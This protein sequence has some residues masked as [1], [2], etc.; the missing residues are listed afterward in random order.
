M[1]E[2]LDQMSGKYSFPFPPYEIQ[3]QLM[4]AIY[5]VLDNRK[6]GVFESPTGTGKSLSIICATIQW[7]RDFEANNLND[8]S[9]TLKSL[10][11]QIDRLDIESKLSSDWIEKQNQKLMINRQKEEVVNELNRLEIKSQRNKCLSDRKNN[12]IIRKKF[13]L[14]HKNLNKKLK[15]DANCDSD[16]MSSDNEFDENFV[17]YCSDEEVSDKNEI[18]LEDPMFVRPKIYYCSRTHSQ[19]SQF[20]N[21]IKKTSYSRQERPLRTVPLGSRSNYCINDS[22]LKLNNS[23]LI[24]EKCIELQNSGNSKTKCQMYKK[25]LMTELKDEILSDAL[26]IEDLIKLGKGV[27][28]CPYYSSRLA[29]PEAEIVIVPYNILL[30]RAQRE[31]FGI[32]L[33][34]NVVI[35]D[36]AHNLIETIHNIHSIELKA[37]Q[38]MDALTQV[39][40]YLFKYKTRLSARNTMHIKQIVFILNE[41]IKH[42]K[43]NIP[44]N[45]SSV[46]ERLEFMIKLGIENLNLYKILDYCEKSKIARKLFGFC[47]KRKQISLENKCEDNKKNINGTSAF[48][49]R[50]KANNIK[51]KTIDSQTSHSNAEEDVKTYGSPLYV[52]QEFLRALININTS[53]KII[54]NYDNNSYLNSSLKYI[55]L[56]PDFHFKV[57]QSL[58]ILF[59]CF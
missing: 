12:S 1:I 8:L 38:V 39:N 22:V 53:A 34:D 31:S 54:T 55:L 20:I 48:L 59:I 17:D 49:A 16:L 56:N 36:E 42:F 37:S 24:N 13:D 3:T 44:T 23:N 5:Q 25:P 19:L 7:I 32:V 57:N 26:D 50:M 41:L 10:N 11:S 14:K 33:K 47:E 9:E 35:V 45:S 28:A 2:V 21:E 58:F 18:P 6:I 29:V 51:I 52:I 46:Y 43:T 27:K 40:L 4:D 15:T 30:H